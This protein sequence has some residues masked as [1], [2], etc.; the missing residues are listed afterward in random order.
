MKAIPGYEDYFIDEDGNVYSCKFGKTRKMSLIKTKGYSIVSIYKNGKRKNIKVHRL[1]YLTFVGEILED[2]V[3]DHIDRDKTNN[4]LS[5]LR[6]VTHQQN[7]FNRDPKGYYWNKRD[8]KWLSYITLNNKKIFLG[9]FDTKEEARSAYLSGKEIYHKLDE[10]P[11][12][13][14]SK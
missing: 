7:G 9:C 13:E 8:K 2:K 5:N 14:E 4:K 10:T 1:V 6:L 11:I 3:I 12:N